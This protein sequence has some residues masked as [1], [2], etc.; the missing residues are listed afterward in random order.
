MGNFELNAFR[1]IIINN[2]LHSIRIL[3]DMCEK[4]RVYCL[5]GIQVDK[6]RVQENVDRSLMLVTA[7][8]PVIG[9][10]KAAAIAH[11]ALDEGTTLREAALATGYIDAAQFEKLVDPAK[12]VG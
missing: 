3:S 5:E 1:P 12:M 4:F 11:K 10:D 2:M 7:L 6:A 8:S 9:Y